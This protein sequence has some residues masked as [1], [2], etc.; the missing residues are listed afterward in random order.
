M[1]ILKPPVLAWLNSL[2]QPYRGRAG[3]CLRFSPF[4]CVKMLMMLCISLGT[5]AFLL[6][7]MPIKAPAQATPNGN[8][9]LIVPENPLTA[10]GLATPYVLVA[11]NPQKGP[12]NETNPAQ[13][14]FVQGAVFDPMTSRIL[15]Y[16]PLVIDKGTRPA[17]APV[18]PTLPKHAIV[19]LWFGFNGNV[20]TLSRNEGFNQGKCV[21]RV[22]NSPFGQFAYCNASTFFS[23]TNE[24]IRDKDLIPPRLGLARDG[25][26]CPSTRDFSVVDQDQSDN[27]T[28]TYLVANGRIA[29]NTAANRAKLPATAELINPSDNKLLVSFIDPA[30]GCRPWMV[31]NLADPGHLTTALPLNELQAAVHQPFPVALVPAGDPMVLVNGRPNLEKLNAFRIGVDQPQVI[32][33]KQASTVVYCQNLRRFGAPRILL[34]APLTKNAPSPDPAM[35][36]FPFLVQRFNVTWGPMG[37]NCAGLL[38]QP[39]PLAS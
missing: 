25:K 4:M 35:N 10:K 28:T 5:E 24:A 9:T 29:Q 11:T 19:A 6:G 1:H 33:L 30:L 3:P 13:S 16:D 22:D 17:I 38:G 7:S 23:A 32:S 27:V 39:S 14:T 37:L 20:L 2:G 36:L 34:D 31:P 18:V 15:I 12:C 21:D 26:T 8:C